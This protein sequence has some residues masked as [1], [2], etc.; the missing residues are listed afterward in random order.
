MGENGIGAPDSWTATKEARAGIDTH[1][2]ER[3]GDHN[4]TRAVDEALSANPDLRA[5][6]ERVNRAA[7]IAK[8]SGA[9]ARPQA[10]IGASGGRQEQKFIGFPVAGGGAG[11]ASSIY[12]SYGSS[13]NVSWEPD[14][15]GKVR[16][17]ERAALADLQSEGAS[18]R[19]ARASL[20]A[21]VA[22]AWLALAEANEQVALA[23]KVLEVRR[24]T[25]KTISERFARALAG[26]GG[27]A[28]DL[29]LA[30]T[31]LATAEATLAQRQGERE[32]AI[33]RLEVFLGRYPSG[34]LAGSAKLPKVPKR[35]PA[36]LPSELLLRRPDILAA[37]R[38]FAAAGQRVKEA[39]LAFFPSFNLTGSMGTATDQLKNIVDSDF[40]IWSIAGHVAQPLLTGGTLKSQLEA[41]RAEDRQALAALQ[42][43][44]LKGFGEVEQALAAE[45]WLAAQEAATA[46]AVERAVDASQAALDDYAGGTGDVLTLLSAQTR[47]VILSSQKITLRRIRLD[48]RVNLHLALGGDYK[49][50]SK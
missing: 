41:R 37:E 42:S 17:G 43:T 18:Y 16:A 34:K 21:E 50:R 11:P 23:K 49:P 2:V 4:M 7:A 31:D 46:K 20:A 3:F 10:G 25:E 29:R 24:N 40:G 14:L 36:G 45:H 44:V 8:A 22:R 32:S 48:N 19:G 39:K 5:A 35:P 30:Q 13:L 47:A 28:A 15:W 27:T 38:R 6:A 26:A 1:W 33:R 9:A 12:S